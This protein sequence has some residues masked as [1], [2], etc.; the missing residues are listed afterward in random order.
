PTPT[1]TAPTPPAPGP[2]ATGPQPV[3]P[4][5]TV[6]SRPA[7]TTIQFSPSSL[8]LVAPPPP[9]TPPSPNDPN[10]VSIVANGSVFAADLVLSFD[11]QAFSIAQIREGGFLS[12]DGQLV[13]VVQRVESDTGTARISLERPPGVAPVSGTGALVTL[14]LEPGTR[15]GASTLKVTDF[16]VRDAR[17]TVQIGRPAEVQVNVP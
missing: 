12:Q 8:K 4:P 15:K 5:A 1:P 14:V 10:T 17:Q 3:S 6:S 16:Q 13:A 7:S 2:T 11:P 9:G